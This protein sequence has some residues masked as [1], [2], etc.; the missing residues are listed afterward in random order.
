VALLLAEAQRQ[1]PPMSRWLRQIAESGRSAL[2]GNVQA[3]TAA[4]FSA[5]AGPGELCRSVVIG[6]YPFDPMSGND[7][8]LD[9]FVRLFA[10]NGALDSFFQSQIRPWVDMSGSVWRARPVGGVAPPVDAA[11]VARFQRAAS[12]RDAFFP[13]GG[14]EPEVRFTVAPVSLDAA[15]KRA[16][17]TLGGTAITDDGH[18]GPAISLAWPGQGGAAQAGLVFDPA[19]SAPLTADG[20]WAL[21]RLLGEGQLVP[22]GGSAGFRLSFRAGAQQASFRL[23]AGSSRS[24]FGRNLLEGFQCP[25]IR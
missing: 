21:F 20:S 10:P 16:T 3:A 19:A 5:S 12:I 22:D 24:P 8:P 14:S 7:A 13:A 15:S 18:D 1:S 4:A 9:D 2:T 23:Q 25:A 6:H 17:L 11:T